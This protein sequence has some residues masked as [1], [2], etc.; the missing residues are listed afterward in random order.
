MTV[1]VTVVAADERSA[2]RDHDVGVDVGRWERLA[3]DVLLDREAHGELT[4]TFVDADEIAALNA[5]YMGRQGPTDVLSFPLDALSGDPPTGQLL[6]GDVVVCPA[7][8]AQQCV[9]HA[10]TLDDELALLV[11]HGVLHVLGHD[12]AEV[13]DAEA[14]RSLE[15]LLLREH[16]WRGDPPSGFRLVHADEAVFDSDVP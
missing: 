3:V 10:G 11:V 7:V 9:E 8:A 16:H 4:L 5:E 15:L 14:M 2:E 13:A 12:H 6:L 1:D